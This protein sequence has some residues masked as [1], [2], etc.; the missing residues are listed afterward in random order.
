MRTWVKVLIVIGVILVLLLAAGYVFAGNMIYS[1]LSSVAG[2]CDQWM[3]NRPDNF[4]LH[5]DWPAF[6]VAPYFMEGWEEVRFPSRDPGIEI[7]GY[8][9]ERTPGG[10][11]AEGPRRAVIYTHGKGGCK[12][13]LEVLIPAGM[14]AR[15]GI[16]VLLIDTRDVGDSTFEDGR[17]AIG[18]E[19][20]LDVLG[21]FDWL[22]GEKGYASE[23]VG[24]AANSLGGPAAV[25][26]FSEEPRIPALFVMATF[27]NLREILDAELEREG[28]PTLLTPAAILAGRLFG[29]DNLVAHTPTTAMEKAAGRPVYI[30]HSRADERISYHQSEQLAAAAR[31]AGADVELWLVDGAGHVQIPAVY[32]EEFEQR[33]VG[34]F[35]QSPGP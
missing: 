14:L 6:D 11:A 8:W 2:T 12:G 17:A 35:R 9:I 31:A 19:E 4:V 32:P 5:D 18:N 33:I 34:F 26:A 3:A 27:G 10:P 30:V 15:N 22:T 16:S 29:G 21:A 24:L 13:A 1:Q 20:Y 23:R 28:Y 25:Y 7:A